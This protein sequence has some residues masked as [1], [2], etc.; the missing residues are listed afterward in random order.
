MNEELGTE[1]AQGSSYS[2]EDVTATPKEVVILIYDFENFTTFLSIPDIHRD[3]ARYLTF[4]DQEVRK[5]FLGGKPAYDAPDEAE[6][7]KLEISII[8]EKF[9]GDG[10][11]FIGEVK[12]SGP[13]ARDSELNELCSRAWNTK[14][15]FERVNSAAMKFMPVTDLPERIRIGITYGTVLELPRSDGEKE[16]IGYAINLAARLQKYAGQ[17]SFLASARLPRADKWL[18]EN[19]FV[20]VRA[21]ALRGRNTELVFI[22]K[23][24]F[25]QSQSSAEGKDL[26]EAV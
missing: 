7:P 25:E 8:H 12:P 1:M 14:E 10:A 26:F 5:I 11:L 24:D 21:K 23:S 2:F 20:K 19:N 22:D 17:A 16:Y 3:L 18:S 4:V 9:L 6:T 13:E 15:F